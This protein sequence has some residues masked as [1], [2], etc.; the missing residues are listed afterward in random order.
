MEAAPEK[1]LGETLGEGG[2]GPGY[3]SGCRFLYTESNLCSVAG[4]EH[5]TAV[6]RKSAGQGEFFSADRAAASTLKQPS[7]LTA[8]S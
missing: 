6:G 1:R 2:R 4:K 3:S 5:V 8:A 7:V